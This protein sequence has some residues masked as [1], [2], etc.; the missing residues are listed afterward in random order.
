[1]LLSNLIF[2]I[3]IQGKIFNDKFDWFVRMDG[4]FFS[5]NITI[6]IFVNIGWCLSVPVVINKSYMITDNCEVFFINESIQYDWLI[7]SIDRSLGCHVFFSIHSVYEM[8]SNQSNEILLVTFDYWDCK[9]AKIKRINS[10][11]TRKNCTKH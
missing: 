9:K 2:W 3:I 11:K 1:M 7:W 4:Y 10:F 5:I 6:A 8:I